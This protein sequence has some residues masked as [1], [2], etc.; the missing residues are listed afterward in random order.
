ME[1]ILSH[2]KD[3]FICFILLV[4]A[5]TLRFI[6][7]DFPP[8]P[9]F[10]EIF[11][12]RAANNYMDGVQD[13]NWVHPPL[14]K[15]LIAAGVKLVSPANVRLDYSLNWQKEHEKLQH[16]PKNT[17]FAYRFSAAVFGALMIPLLYLFSLKLFKNRTIAI[18]AA[19]LLNFDFLLFVLS[20][21]ALLDIF[22]SFFMLLAS[23]LLWLAIV[24]DDLN[25]TALYLSAFAAGLA[26]AC[27][28]NGV[29]VFPLAVVALFIYARKR[30]FVESLY[31]FCIL[32]ATYLL[33]YTYYFMHGG[34]LLNLYQSIHNTLVFQY[35]GFQHAYLT[36]LWKIVFNIRDIWF[37]YDRIGFACRG[38]VAVGNPIFWWGFFP[39]FCYYAYKTIKERDKC[40]IFLI[41]GYITSFIFWLGCT[42]GCFF[43]YMAQSV[44]WMVL[45]TAAFLYRLFPLKH[46]KIYAFSY[47][48][49]ILAAFPIFYRLMTGLLLHYS[50]FFYIIFLKSWI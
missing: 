19:L 6:Y 3:I 44:P 41:F 17:M 43:Y 28:W 45:I 29:F 32:C 35:G 16:P 13:T 30:C 20:R 46:G 12:Q 37:Y 8:T 48:G 21:I 36:T 24:N 31:Y 18:M 34:T 15:I 1:N 42:R 27:K 50:Y 38:I 4:V 14:G 11:Y 40:G 39:I 7:L 33:S 47:F 23:Y 22:L 2:K 5:L 49:L 25:R 9:Y 26:V 10:D